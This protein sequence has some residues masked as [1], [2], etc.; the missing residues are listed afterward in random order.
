ML[1]AI[2][3]DDEK[4]ALEVLELL[5][6]RHCPQIET[7]ALCDNGVKAINAINKLRP[8]VVFIDIDMPRKNTVPFRLSSIS[9]KVFA[10]VIFLP[11]ARKIRV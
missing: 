7:I 2:L 8:D 11:L 1:R 4:N 3:V 5:L 10:S 9:F 6:K